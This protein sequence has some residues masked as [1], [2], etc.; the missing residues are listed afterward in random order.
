[1]RGLGNRS[2]FVVA[3]A[4]TIGARVSR[5]LGEEGAKV[6]VTDLD[7]ASAERVVAD[8]E[9]SGGNAIALSI[10]VTD[11]RSVIAAI[12][13]ARTAFGSIDAAHINVA[14]LS[15][16]ILANDSDAVSI[17]LDVFDRVIA[18]NLR[19]HLV[20]TKHLVPELI[21]RGGGPI[22]YT[23]SA[24][25]YMAAPRMVAYG[26]SKSA[27]HALV[28]HVGAAYG[29]K[30][31]RANAVAPG[32]VLDEANGRERDPAVLDGLLA[33]T[34]SDRLGSPEDIAAI[35]ALLLSDDAE[36][37]NGQIISVDGGITRRP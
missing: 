22:V 5:R 8:I 18:V 2:V 21:G 25:A 9:A 28:R 19:G 3:G 30:G 29:K 36:W 35:V 7:I 11:E 26:M 32:L 1:M 15:P 6:A 24:G 12:E 20:C 10:D 23:S 34:L 16:A 31:I 27:L 17:D 4:G 14:D 13:S 33:Q 37:V